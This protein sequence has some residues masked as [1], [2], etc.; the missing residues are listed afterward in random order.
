MESPDMQPNAPVP[1]PRPVQRKRMNVIIGGFAAIA[2]VVTIILATTIHFT[3]DSDMDGRPDIE[4]TY[5]E[6]PY[7]WSDNDN[8]GVG[9]NADEFPNN[10]KYHVKESMKGYSAGSCSQCL[11]FSIDME[12]FKQFNYVMSVENDILRMTITDPDGV[13]VLQEEG[14]LFIGQY[15][16]Y[17]GGE[18]EMLFECMPSTPY[19]SLNYEITEFG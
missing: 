13:L 15:D 8:D 9:D 5:P 11:G 2:I 12:G 18:W 17:S 3:W 1:K 6:N 10:P 19:L 4:D 7:E 14:A 16:W